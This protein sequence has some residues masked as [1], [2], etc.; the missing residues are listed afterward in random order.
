MAYSLKRIIKGFKKLGKTSQF[1]S[2]ADSLWNR[3][4]DDLPTIVALAIALRR[5]KSP[6]PCTGHIFQFAHIDDQFVFASIIR[7]FEACANCGAVELSTRPLTAIMSQCLN[8]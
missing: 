2:L 7:S 6:E 1:Q 5:Q 3:S 8:S 4:K